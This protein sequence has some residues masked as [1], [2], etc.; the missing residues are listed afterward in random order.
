M[1]K[2]EPPSRLLRS[3]PGSRK[4]PELYGSCMELLWNV[5]GIPLVHQASPARA[6]GWQHGS[7][8]QLRPLRITHPAQANA[9]ADSLSPNGVSPVPRQPPLSATLALQRLLLNTPNLL[10]ANVGLRSGLNREGAK[11]RRLTARPWARTDCSPTLPVRGSM[12]EVRRSGFDVGCWMFG[13]R[14]TSPKGQTLAPRP[15]PPS[16]PIPAD[17]ASV[18]PEPRWT[19]AV[20]PLIR[21]KRCYGESPA[22]LRRGPHALRGRQASVSRAA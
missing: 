14:L 15:P 3:N 21:D 20:A 7:N 6:A 16:R 9:A 4:R 1:W 5:Y 19:L 22:N 2:S 13:P 8:T 17:R 18:S 10:E 11:T 12:R